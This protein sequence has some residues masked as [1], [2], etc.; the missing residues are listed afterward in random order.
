[1]MHAWFALS[2]DERLTKRCATEGCGSQPI[3][4]LEADGIGANYCSG[5]RFKNNGCPR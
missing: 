3:W 4:R 1:M 2:N 5:C